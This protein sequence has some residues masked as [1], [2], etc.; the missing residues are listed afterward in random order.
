MNG[1]LY[2]EMHG[3]LVK[4]AELLKME[5][6]MG[7]AD[8]QRLRLYAWEDELFDAAREP[9]MT[10]A[11]CRQ[12]V[13]EVARRYFRNPKLPS[14]VPSTGNVAKG[15]FDEILL[16][17]WARRRSVVLHETAHFILARKG[18]CDGHGPLFARLV[19]EL[20]VKF[21]GISRLRAR[22]VAFRHGTL[23]GGQLRFAPRRKAPQPVP[24]KKKGR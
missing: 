23:H 17:G 2:I 15:C 24:R 13:A 19:L 4:F 18:H 8:S 11:E 21:G 16:P 9:E 20:Y 22:L 7:A 14:V 10:M 6:L 1:A 3:E 5:V 12:L